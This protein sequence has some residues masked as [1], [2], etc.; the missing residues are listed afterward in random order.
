VS[1]KE[2]GTT[3]ATKPKTMAAH[4]EVVNPTVYQ[5]DKY[6]EPRVATVFIRAVDSETNQPIENVRVSWQTNLG[7]IDRP[8]TSTTTDSNG[9]ARCIFYSFDKGKAQIRARLEKEGYLPTETQA[10]VEVVQTATKLVVVNQPSVGEIFLNGRKVGEGSVEMMISTPGIYI[11]S[12]GDV[13]GYIAPE[14][15]KLYI[16]PNYSVEPLK[17][18]G[19]YQRPGERDYIY[20]RVFTCITFDDMTGVP[21]PV[22]ECPV[23]L[24]DGQQAVTDQSGIAVFKVKAN[25][26]PL[27]ITAKHPK[28]YEY[29]QTAEVEVKERDIHVNLDFGIFFGGE[30]VVGFSEY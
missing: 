30:A 29:Y 22:P 9:I 7:F 4:V 1:E 5:A 21:N 15:V 26:G 12:W 24:S 8:T 19:L 11:L 18:E 27:K 28:L 2:A 13:E 6:V 3:A 20:L 14:P 10:E 25:S 16:N 23:M 17:I